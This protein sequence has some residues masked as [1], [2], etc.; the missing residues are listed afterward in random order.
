MAAESVKDGIRDFILG[1]KAC[2][3]KGLLL[4]ATE[5]MFKAI[6]HAVDFFIYKVLGKTPD[7]H[8]ERFDI[9]KDLDKKLYELVSQLF[10]LYRKSYRENFSKEE[11]KKVKD[12][13]RE[14]LK[15]T[16]LEK[17]FEKYLQ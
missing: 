9:L 2:E 6:L 7:N 11:F 8:N 16:G 4:P 1:S 14:T 17:E 5:N 15:I 13:L 12:G 10:L 3:D